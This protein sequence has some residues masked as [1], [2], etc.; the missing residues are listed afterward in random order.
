VQEGIK[1]KTLLTG[2]LLF[3]SVSV[4]LGSWICP[5]F[6]QEQMLAQAYPESLASASIIEWTSVIRPVPLTN[7]FM[8]AYAD[9]DYQIN[10]TFVLAPADGTEELY[11]CL[12]LGVGPEEQRKLQSI[13]I[14]GAPAQPCSMIAINATEMIEEFENGLF[15][16]RE[17]RYGDGLTPHI[18]EDI[19]SFRA[20]YEREDD[21]RSAV[22]ECACFYVMLYR[23]EDPEEEVIIEASYLSQGWT[24]ITGA[25]PLFYSVLQPGLWQNPISGSTISVDMSGISD[26]DE[27]IL[28]QGNDIRTG[29]ENLE[30]NMD[31]LDECLPDAINGLTITP[32]DLQ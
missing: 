26:R 25:F 29:N 16:F 3:A 7:E 18:L 15:M 14:N 19:E 17:K 13:S 10:E 27:W 23:I 20:R 9:W 32:P 12:D 8:S 4:T 6:T 28:E 30:F 5:V 22:P 2:L 1:L 11:F 24:Y 31:G 21:F